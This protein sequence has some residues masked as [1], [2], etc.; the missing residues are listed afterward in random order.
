MLFTPLGYPGVQIGPISLNMYTAPAYV[1]NIMIIIALAVICLSFEESHSA[2][3]SANSMHGIE[4]CR[5]AYS[6][7][8]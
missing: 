3:S 4:C 8:S 7:M 6:Y 2:I 1:A 5:Y